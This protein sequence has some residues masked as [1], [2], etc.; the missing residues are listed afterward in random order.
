MAATLGAA[1]AAAMR[2]VDRVHSR[3][4]N[5]RTLALPDVAA[6]LAD[7]FVHVIRVRDGAHR[8]HAGERDLAD[9]TGIEAE[10]RVTGIAAEIL[11]I[12]AGRACDLT[13]LAW[14]H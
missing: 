9:F 14:L 12:G 10:Q 6:G 7:H 2:M 13:A 5:G 11:R 8:R 3:T 4:A 1:F